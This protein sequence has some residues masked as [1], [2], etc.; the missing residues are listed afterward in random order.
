MS[1]NQVLAVVSRTATGFSGG[2]PDVPGA[3]ATGKD[4]AEVLR[5]LSEVLALQLL[6]GEPSSFTTT[7]VDDLEEGETTYW[8]KPAPINPVSLEIAEAI[9]RTGK[10]LRK[11]APEIGIN[12]AVLSR[13]QDPFYWG[14][15]L[16]SLRQLAD[17]LGLNLQISL[18]PAV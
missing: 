18:K 9:A 4:E 7:E 3:I 12:Y 5:H 6:D 16:A 10:S 17:G 2:F 15:S 13:L 11:L 8:I 14:H 1:P